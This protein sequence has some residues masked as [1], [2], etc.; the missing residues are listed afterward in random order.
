MGYT[1]PNIDRIARQGMM[2]YNQLAYLTGQQ[3]RGARRE[4]FYFNDDGDL[5][6]LRYENWKVVFEEQRAPGTLR[7]WAKPFTKLRLVKLFDLRADPHER[8]DITSNTY[9][10][11]F[12]SNAAVVYGSVG[13]VS[14]FL[15]TFKEFPPSQRAASFTIDQAVDKLRERIG[16]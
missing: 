7:V 4:F 1:T 2:F 16:R 12:I 6:G 8:A 5:V 11:W 9:Y 14:R 15:E 10:D 13:I 3:E